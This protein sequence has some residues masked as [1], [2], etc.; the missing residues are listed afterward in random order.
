M[1]PKWENNGFNGKDEQKKSNEK[2][3]EKINVDD[4]V[5]KYFSF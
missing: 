5:D 2:V 3:V 4:S 1:G